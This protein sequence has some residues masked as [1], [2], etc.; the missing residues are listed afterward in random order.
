L[1]K[2]LFRRLSLAL[3][4]VYSLQPSS[5]TVTAGGGGK[6]QLRYQRVIQM[7]Y[8]E[9]VG[10]APRIL[11]MRNRWVLSPLVAINRAGGSKPR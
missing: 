8:G 5:A 1:S 9:R 6:S 3:A 2:R 10:Q 11:Q 7:G 4:A